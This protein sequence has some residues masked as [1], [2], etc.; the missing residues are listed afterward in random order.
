MTAQPYCGM[1][2]YV[3]VRP[4]D[5]QFLHG[6]VPSPMH[7]TFLRWHASQALFAVAGAAETNADGSDMS[8]ACLKPLEA[9]VTSTGPFK[10]AISIRSHKT[11]GNER[12]CRRGSSVFSSTRR[13]YRSLVPDLHSVA[14]EEEEEEQAEDVVR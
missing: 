8:P 4:A 14:V 5:V 9:T 1:A 11:Y 2:L 3:H 10:A 6:L 12:I 7:F 13:A